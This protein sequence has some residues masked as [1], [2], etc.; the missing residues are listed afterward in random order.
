M[1]VSNINPYAET[2]Q[3]KVELY[4]G[5][6]LSQVC[7]CEDVLQDFTV[8]RVGE[9]NKFFGYGICQKTNINLIDIERAI[10]ISTANSFKN[11]YGVEGEFITPYPTFYVTEVNRDE[12]TNT[13]SI[14]AYDI[15]YKASALTVS[16]LELPEGY[17]IQFLMGRVAE[18]IGATDFVI[19]GEE[20]T[21]ICFSLYYDNG[22]NFSGAENLRAVLN[23]IAEATQT[24]YYIDNQERLVFKRLDLRGEA[25]ETVTRDYYFTLESKTN[26]RL[27]A[28][29]NATELGDN[30]TAELDAAGTTQ[31]I[32]N[33][34]LL[35]LLE[36]G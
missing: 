8:E 36:D 25:V 22:A 16:D 14:T 15:L 2:V 19:I 20:T 28:I 11:Y 29:C 10:N 9:S 31:Y 33:N 17:D 3:G 12:N 26:R 6:T 30:V 1:I 23:A 7:T 34:P 21:D 35:E 27:S 32:R 24:I 18:R 13:I 4:T 5:S